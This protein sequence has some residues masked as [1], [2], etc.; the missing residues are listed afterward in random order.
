MGSTFYHL[1]LS[2]ADR[3][4]VGL[5]ERPVR[6]A[7]SPARATSPVTLREAAPMKDGLPRK[8]YAYA[9][10]PDP[11]TWKL[12]YLTASGAPDPDRLPGAVAALS[13]GGFRGQKADIPANMVAAVKA[14]L[15]TAY[16]KWKGGDVEYPDTIKE[17]TYTYALDEEQPNA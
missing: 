14:K 17:S 13:P 1:R 16:R 3:A 8:A 9:P 2:E 6:E 15:R 11:S 10:T 5:V 12:P 7:V 4:A